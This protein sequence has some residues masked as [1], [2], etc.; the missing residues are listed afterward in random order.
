MF[1]PIVVLE[2]DRSMVSDMFCNGINYSTEVCMAEVV[3]Y[4]G[5]GIGNP[6]SVSVSSIR[7]LWEWEWGFSI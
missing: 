7:M 1:V 4:A 3:E 5:V 2:F 6:C